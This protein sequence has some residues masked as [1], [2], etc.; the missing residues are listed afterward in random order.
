[1]SSDRFNVFSSNLR[2]SILLTKLH[3]LL[4]MLFLRFW[5]FIKAISLV[6]DFLYSCH[7][8]FCQRVRREGLG[9]VGRRNVRSGKQFERGDLWRYRVQQFHITNESYLEESEEK[10]EKPKW[11]DKV[12][13]LNQKV[14]CS[15]LNLYWIWHPQNLDESGMKDLIC[16]RE[17]FQLYLM[18]TRTQKYKYISR[19]NLSLSLSTVPA[20]PQMYNGIF[21][22][23]H[24]FS[25]GTNEEYFW[26]ES[27]K[28]GRNKDGIYWLMEIIGRFDCFI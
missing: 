12:I 16:T 7:R 21:K 3:T 11:S 17:S 4:L 19:G 15:Q 28:I 26:T 2:I 27:L 24:C 8:S 20:R 25:S 5:T 1:M 13:K 6:A 18:V 9:G 14:L 23:L 22:L 10:S